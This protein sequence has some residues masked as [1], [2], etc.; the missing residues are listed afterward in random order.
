MV[1]RPSARTL[2]SCAV[3]GSTDEAVLRAIVSV[4]GAE[5]SRVHVQGGKAGVR[6]ALP[7]YNSAAE[8]A[9]W[10][11]LVDLDRD[12][13]CAG[14]LVEEWL[15]KPS[16]GMALRVAV[17]EVEAWLLADK[18]R[19]SSFFSVRRGRLP[20]RPDELDD[21]KATVVA[22]AQSSTSKSVR[23][24]MV[25]R[26]GSGRRVGPAYASRLIEFATEK[27]T[28]WRPDVAAAHSPSLARSVRR[29]RSLLG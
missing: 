5:V 13:P 1:A 4:C 18:D 19:F 17:R 12:A 14:A 9:P 23:V 26:P 3:E 24:D 25:P 2:V 8:R 28:G 16:A 15:P 27:V 10:I 11:V 7:G 21:P 20:E 22:L 6:R 29:I